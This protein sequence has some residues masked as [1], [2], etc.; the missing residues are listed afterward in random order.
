[1]PKEQQIRSL[2]FFERNGLALGVQK[3]DLKDVWRQDLNYC[4]HLPG[5]QPFV[6][7]VNQQRDYVEQFHRRRLHRIF[8]ARNS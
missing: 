4:P 3:L 1:M 6:R 2:Q 7:L 5:N 8:I